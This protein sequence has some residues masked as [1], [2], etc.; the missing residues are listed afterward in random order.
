M[1]TKILAIG[2]LC[3]IA[4]GFFGCSE[5][6]DG[7]TEPS[8]AAPSY[9]ECMKRLDNCRKGS[10]FAVGFVKTI[11]E[12][13]KSKS[14]SNA[15]TVPDNV[16]NILLDVGAL[17]QPMD[18]SMI[19][20]I[21]KHPR[22]SPYARDLASAVVNHVLGREQRVAPVTKDILDVVDDCKIFKR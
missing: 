2:A 13:R 14:I 10:P 22:S 11:V 9:S 7:K 16:A 6:N 18:A 5:K 3:S 17:T 8:F 1:N 12:R 4:V 21:K 19:D 15:D 20:K